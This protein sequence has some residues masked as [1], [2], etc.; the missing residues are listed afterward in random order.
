MTH[1]RVK[2]WAGRVRE[3]C[4]T[5]GD[6]GGTKLKQMF[7]ELETP[8]DFIEKLHEYSTV[9]P[10]RPE[11]ILRATESAVVIGDVHGDLTALLVILDHMMY[12]YLDNP[13]MCVLVGDFLD[14]KRGSRGHDLSYPN[15]ELYLIQIIKILGIRTVLGNH[16]LMRAKREHGYC[17]ST[18]HCAWDRVYHGWDVVLCRYLANTCPIIIKVIVGEREYLLMH[19]LAGQEGYTLDTFVRSSNGN[20][21]DEINTAAFDLLKQEGTVV[22]TS[23]HMVE[24][25][26][27]GRNAAYGNCSGVD[28]FVTACG[29]K[30]GTTIIVGHTPTEI[31]R[32][33]SLC[34]SK[35]QT[36][37]K[38]LSADKKMSKAFIFIPKSNNNAH[39]ELDK[40]TRH[41]MY[42]N[43]NSAGTSPVCLLS[44]VPPESSLPNATSV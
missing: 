37:A 33:E 27:W 36:A 38:V 10:K 42:W 41:L 14:G 17:S 13:P 26:V 2:K 1:G 22:E 24:M 12:F 43:L 28:K 8:H 23:S 39:D 16:E 4:Y 7:P 31:G 30:K 20:I 21:I 44:Q 15:E 18:Q 32:N 34:K 3:L 9:S 25:A 11:A 29:C 19:T 35:Y 6:I 40:H 5:T